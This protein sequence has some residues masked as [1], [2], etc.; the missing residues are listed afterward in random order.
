MSLSYESLIY[1]SKKKKEK[2]K[3]ITINGNMF[4]FVAKREREK[5][6]YTFVTLY[7]GRKGRIARSDVKYQ[8]LYS[9]SLL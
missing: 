5:K 7:Y 1:R 4:V 2:K 8:A 6:K 3:K 9:D